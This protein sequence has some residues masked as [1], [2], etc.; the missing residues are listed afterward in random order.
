MN[1]TEIKKVNNIS[2]LYSKYYNGIQE[3][4]FIKDLVTKYKDEFKEEISEED[5][6]LA[7][8]EIFSAREYYEKMKIEEERLNDREISERVHYH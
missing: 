1:L 2:Y 4:T 5:A 3:T 8:F 6:E 7:L